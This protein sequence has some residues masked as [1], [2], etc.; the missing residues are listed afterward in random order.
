[1]PQFVVEC[2]YSHAAQDDSIIHFGEPGASH[3]HT[4]FGNTTTDAFS[5]VDS[6]LAGGSTCDPVTDR[7]AY[8][9]PA[10]MRD[11]ELIEP[12][13]FA[14]YYRP[15]PDVDPASVVPYPTGLEMIAG[16]AGATT[17][18]PLSVVAWA[19][20]SGSD[21]RALPPECASPAK[22][23]HLIVTFPD[24]WDGEHLRSDD[25][26]SHVAYGAGGACPASHP[27]SVP[28]LQLSIEYP[29]SGSVAGLEL[30]SGGLLTGHADFVNAW[31]PDA[32]ETEIAN[33][34]HREVVC[35][36]RRG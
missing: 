7:A 22:P 1:M 35:A 4:F 21:H 34:L 14:A 13:G 6:L 15:G 17:P 9:A 31:E 20:G 11:G 25:H 30:A 19:C 23:L 33:C 16:N 29:V 27:V 10:L 18:Q 36:V 8:W 32:L 2:G 24:C 28:Q 26:I 3:L 5:T 12:S